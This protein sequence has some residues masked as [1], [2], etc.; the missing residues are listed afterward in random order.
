MD[1]KKT[2]LSVK[3]LEKLIKFC[4][5]NGVV[6]LNYENMHVKFDNSSPSFQ[7]PSQ[8]VTRNAKKTAKIAE[9]QEQYN[10][11]NEE[12]EVS[13]LEDPAAYEEAI[14]QGLLQREEI[15]DSGSQ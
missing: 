6:E 2:R 1:V 8:A 5:N 15:R 4:R 13:H 14:V 7:K 9:I 12:L 10:L 11:V 3:N